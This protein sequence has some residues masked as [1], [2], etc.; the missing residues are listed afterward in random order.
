MNNITKLSQ[1]VL[2]ALFLGVQIFGV[3]AQD[4]PDFTLDTDNDG[5]TDYEEKAIYQT[6]WNDAD[7]DNDGYMDGVEVDNGYSPWHGNKKKMYEVDTDN[8][9]VNDA[10]ELALGTNILV[11]DSD[12]DGY[13]DGVE[14]Q[15]SYS[16]TSKEPVKVDKRIEVNIDG[17]TL[18]A[19]HG[20][21][22]VDEFA[23]STGR[24]GWETP[25]GDFTVKEKVPVKNY[26]GYPNT[27]YNLE[28]AF[29]HGWKDYI[30]QANW[31]DEFGKK[32]MSTGCVN[33]PV[34][35]MKPLYEWAQVGTPVKVF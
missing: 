8:D 10:W 15:N 33:V 4:N 32:N 17:Y 23:I 18:A 35:K 19:Y 9:G 3:S 7:T 2:T 5:L 24:K 12:N 34:G 29:A 1:I 26:Y 22:K 16:P 27:P 20:D 31:H 14:I 25:R 30:H 13:K 21:I 11:Q 28:F 6:F